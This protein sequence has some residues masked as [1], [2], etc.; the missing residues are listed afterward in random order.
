[1][2][3]RVHPSCVWHVHGMHVQ[4][5]TPTLA[6]ERELWAMEAELQR[7][8]QSAAEQQ[9]R[10]SGSSGRCPMRRREQHLARPRLE[11]VKVQVGG[12][13]EVLG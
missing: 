10:P 4:V 12:I 2:H 9:R 8:M 3:A 7:F 6:D 1:M 5:S 13:S 11:R